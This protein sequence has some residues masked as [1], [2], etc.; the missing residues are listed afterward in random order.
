MSDRLLMPTFLCPKPW[1]EM[2][3]DETTRFCSYCQ[4][5]VHNLVTLSTQDRLALLSSPAGSICARYR[6]AIRRPAKGKKESYMRH[7][8]KYGATV[9]LSGSVLLVLW[10]M[11]EQGNRPAY[12]RASGGSNGSSTTI[13]EWPEELYKEREV[14]TLGIMTSLEE[15]MN[16]TSATEASQVDRVDLKLDPVTI[17]QLFEE[18]KVRS[19][20][21]LP[22]VRLESR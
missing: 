22:A 18:A 16:P 11:Y 7:M 21:V 17:D 3:G 15:P 13:C 8:L 2:T 9:A 12:Y 5:H 14:V 20:G 1:E 19:F 10:E 4:K 6:V